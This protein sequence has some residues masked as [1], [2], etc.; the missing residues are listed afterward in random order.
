MFFE[1]FK[2]KY[3]VLADVV[4][5]RKEEKFENR[6]LHGLLDYATSATGISFEDKRDILHHKLVFFSKNVDCFDFEKLLE[7][8]KSNAKL[9]QELIDYLTV[10]ETYFNREHSQIDLFVKMVKA[11]KDRVELLSLPCSTGEEVDTIIITL[12]E[13][14]VSTDK[15]CITGMDINATV[16]AH[17]KNAFYS[18]RSL[19]KVDER[20]VDKYFM[21]VDETFQLNAKISD[22]PEF[23]TG[24]IFELQNMKNFDFIFCRNLLIYFDHD[25]KKEAIT[26]LSKVLKPEGK[27][28]FGH[29][30]TID[31]SLDLDYHYEDHAKYYELPKR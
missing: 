21:K 13:A 14:G 25:T 23:K 15:F 9:R 19:H 7:K 24:S 4:H 2:K 5:E 1:M 27:L 6:G 29:G 30:D 18:K 16:V 28:F 12:L 3:F 31:K 17:A 26:S 10:N 8:I 20:L 11:S 22:I